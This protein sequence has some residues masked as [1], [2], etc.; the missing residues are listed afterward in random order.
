MTRNFR[1]H[2]YCFGMEGHKNHNLT[3]SRQ[4]FG[5]NLHTKIL[6]NQDDVLKLIVRQNKFGIQEVSSKENHRQL[7]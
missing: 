6:K 7:D 3:G 5:K 2:K 1:K 4:K